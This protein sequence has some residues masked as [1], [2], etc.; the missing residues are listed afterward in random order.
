V[1]SIKIRILSISNKSP[2]WINQGIDHFLTKFPQKIRPELIEIRSI[3]KNGDISKFLM[4]EKLKIM[5]LVDPGSRLI[6]LDEKGKNLTS[7]RLAQR[8]DNW[9]VE[10]KNVDLVLGGAEGLHESFKSEADELI[11]LSMLT[12]PHQMARLFLI[13]ALYRASSILGNHPYHRG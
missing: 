2:A 4:S 11:S 12:L 8:L 13:E 6:V 7:A 3:K 1:K 5:N 10:G 9:R